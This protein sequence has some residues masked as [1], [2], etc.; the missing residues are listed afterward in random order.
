MVMGVSTRTASASE[1]TR[2]HDTGDQVFPSLIP[3]TKST[4]GMGAATWTA[5]L[6][7]DWVVILVQDAGERITIVRDNFESWEIDSTTSC[8]G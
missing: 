8:K 6:N 2:V 3:L 5:N 1:Y 7:G 4:Q